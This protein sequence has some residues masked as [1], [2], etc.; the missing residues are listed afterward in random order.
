MLIL[1]FTN[2][3][4]WDGDL[5]LDESKTCSVCGGK[6][7]LEDVVDEMHDLYEELGKQYRCSNFDCGNVNSAD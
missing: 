1:N 4:I 3:I 7:Y 2:L 5:I 6:M